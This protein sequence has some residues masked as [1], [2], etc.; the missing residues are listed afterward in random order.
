VVPELDGSFPLG[1][2]VNAGMDDSAGVVPGTPFLSSPPG[3]NS[4]E[5][6]APGLPAGLPEGRVSGG[7]VPGGPVPGAAADLPAG[8]V[9][10]PSG[11]PGYPP[12][13][14]GD[15]TAYAPGP[16]GVSPGAPPG[17]A[18]VPPGLEPGQ[19]HLVPGQ[20]DFV[21]SRGDFV[22]GQGGTG[23]QPQA[24]GATRPSPGRTRPA[25]HGAPGSG[26]SG[27]KPSAP[28]RR[29]RRAKVAALAIV[30][31]GVLVI[32]LASGFGSE[33]SAEPNAQAFL[34]SWQQQQYA[35]AARLTT[36]EPGSVTTSMRTAV[37]QLDATQL[38]LSLK[39]VVQH[40]GTADVSFTATVDLAQQGRVWTYDGHFGMRRVNGDWKVVWAPSVINPRLGPGERLAVVTAFPAR[41]AVLDAAGKP[42]QLPARAYVLGVWPDRL[43][44]PAQTAQAFAKSTKLQAGQVLGQIAAAPPQQFLRLATLDPDSYATVRASLR[45][46][47][48]LVVRPESQRLF[49]AEATG[50]VGSVGSELSERLR[51][52]GAFY[53][54]GTTI[55]LSGLEQKYQRQL[56][57]TPTTEVVAVNSAGQQTG[58]LAQW[59]G[60]TGTPVQTTISSAAQNAALNALNQVPNSGEIVAVKA[61]TGEVL[62]V[63]QH[64]ASGV[65]PAAGAL[66]ARLV[67][68]GAFTIVSA[69]ALLSHGVSVKSQTSCAG[70]FTVGGQTFTSEGSGQQKPFSEVFADGCS[71]AF[72]GLS[73]RLTASQWAQ[74][75][76]EFGIGANWS[77][78]PV[79]AFSGSV[80]PA[81]GDDATL[82]AQTIGQG[83]V[84]VSLLSMAMVAAAVDAG[85]W[86]VPQVIKAPASPSA[87]GA[88]LDPDMTKALQGLMRGAVRSG[89]AHAAR[90]PGQQVYGQVG[91]VRTGSGWMSWFV[92]YRGDTAIAAIESGKT[93]RLSAAA[94]AGVFFSALGR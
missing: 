92:G 57:G 50:L 9:P 56:L 89:A 61:S 40:G 86:H 55:G 22:P 26:S 59:R 3:P 44:D 28:S 76:K 14:P 49:Q 13:A 81:A 41:A 60:V 34:Y 77:Q 54:P 4:S 31:I 20:A 38:F 42:L 1:T 7:P 53:A 35:A 74:V 36:G 58:V 47:P 2:G 39:S 69:G 23:P 93:A 72:A 68:G 78:L 16:P 5:P 8:F 84:R 19:A 65:L 66:N 79:P 37:T 10:S 87:A 30:V 83:N 17:Y 64:Q 12:A 32:G 71:T 67:P 52:D 24:A 6:D 51:A 94:L 48:G 27:R 80:P 90:L 46:V 25:R 75:I 88:P 62:A 73:E 15:L 70:S 11:E 21:P 29:A 33:L 18:P 63:A 82:A 85:S 43:S 91:M 45:R